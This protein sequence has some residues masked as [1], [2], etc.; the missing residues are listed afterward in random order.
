MTAIETLPTAP[1]PFQQRVLQFRRHA[2]IA[3]LGGRG[4]GKSVS[5]LFDVLDHVRELGPVASVLVLRESWAGLQELS[6]K[7]FQ[8]GRIAFGGAVSQNKG[9]GTLSFP[10]GAMVY[11]KNIGDADSFASAQGR[12][13]TMIAADEAGN[14]P[15]SAINYLTML[16]SNLRPPKGI[17]AHM[18]ITAN[19]MGRAHVH[20]LRNFVNKAPPWTPYQSEEGEWWINCFSDLTDNPSLDADAYRRQLLAATAGNPAL[21]QAWL[22]GDW[23]Q[24]GGGLMFDM[25]DPKVH[26]VEPP[27]THRY[28]FVVGGDY[29]SASPSAMILLGELLDPMQNYIP[30]DVFALD[31]RHTCIEAGNYSQGDGSPPSVL[32]AMVKTMLGD[33]GLNPAAVPVVFDDFRGFSETVIGVLQ[34]QGLRSASKPA[35]KD[36]LGTFALMRNMLDG[37]VHGDSKALFL[38]PRVGP[39]IDTIQVAPRDDLRTEDLSRHWNEDHF[40]DALGYGLLELKD[41]PRSGTGRVIGMW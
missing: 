14:Y 22:F 16:R 33:W 37:A 4:S 5:L 21:Q 8:L 18:H 34:E 19:P 24:K 25:F 29:G 10:N 32:A 11:F 28:K 41:A 36:R 40:V 13:Y 39:L 9:S 6:F 20:F 15:I 35:R 7:L 26:I 17:R 2:N 3:N 30:G 12:T 38:S 23:H 27:R 31:M 1:S